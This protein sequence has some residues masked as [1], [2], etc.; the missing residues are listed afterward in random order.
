MTTCSWSGP[1][2]CGAQWGRPIPDDSVLFRRRPEG[3]HRSVE[4]FRKGAWS[5]ESFANMVVSTRLHLFEVD[6]EGSPVGPLG[7]WL[8]EPGSGSRDPAASRG[9]V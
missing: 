1:I 5:P 8:S 9:V 2:S 6:S 7:V 4:V 3:S